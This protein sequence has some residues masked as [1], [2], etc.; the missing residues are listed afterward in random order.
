MQFQHN[1]PDTRRLKAGV[2]RETAKSNLLESQVRFVVQEIVIIETLFD[3]ACAPHVHWHLQ[4]QSEPFAL[5]QIS[6]MNPT[7]N[8]AQVIVQY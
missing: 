5:M 6:L 3:L 8:F 1:L 2:N 4:T 7:N